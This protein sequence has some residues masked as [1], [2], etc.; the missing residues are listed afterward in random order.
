MT[1]LKPSLHNTSNANVV[2]CSFVLDPIT[3]DALLLT[4]DEYSPLDSN[5]SELHFQNEH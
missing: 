4:P 5:C 2:R 3:I 1:A